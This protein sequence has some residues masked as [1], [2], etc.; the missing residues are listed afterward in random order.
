M[1]RLI[2]I[3]LFFVCC[4]FILP[5][6]KVEDPFRSLGLRFI[7]GQV[8]GALYEHQCEGTR[9]Y[10]YEY[11]VGSKLYQQRYDG[12]NQVVDDRIPPD[13]R[14]SGTLTSKV[15]LPVRYFKWFPIWSEPMEAERLSIL[16][17]IMVNA[18]KIISIV[19]L[20]WIFVR[21]S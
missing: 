1:M 11:M 20:I 3:A 21:R 18:V 7:Y 12:F 4:F 9:L 10:R 14:C 5:L 16:L 8:E 6:F 19:L 13:M 15:T 17:F 2:R